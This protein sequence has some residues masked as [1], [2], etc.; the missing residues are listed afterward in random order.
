MKSCFF[1]HIQKF[2]KF[3]LLKYASSAF[4]CIPDTEGCSKQKA[5]VINTG[6]FIPQRD[7]A[8]TVAAPT[9][10][11]HF[12]FCSDGTCTR[13]K[14]MRMILLQVSKIVQFGFKISWFI[15]TFNM[16]WTRRSKHSHFS[17]CQIY[18]AFC[19]YRCLTH[20]LT[21]PP[22]KISHTVKLWLILKFSWF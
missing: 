10:F 13:R 12:C 2:L 4:S 17:S 15:L 20:P 7:A 8:K 9:L 6:R 3:T 11:K 18:Q 19:K 14:G 21:T 1:L 5:F 16:K 22:S